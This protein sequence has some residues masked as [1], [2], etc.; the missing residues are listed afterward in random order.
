MLSTAFYILIVF[1]FVL[2][3]FF[4]LLITNLFIFL[5]FM[6]LHFLIRLF[7]L[8]NI[9]Q[10]LNF[11]ENPLIIISLFNFFCFVTFSSLL[12][13]GYFQVMS[14]RFISTIL[15]YFLVW[16][17]ILDTSIVVR[18]YLNLFFLN[19]HLRYYSF[20]KKKTL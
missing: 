3:S 6:L 1:L 12:V 17:Q 20:Q 4:L 14:T 15:F 2:T 13:Q 19:R 8:H 18:F 5:V 10:S 7:L 9:T 16:Y 11:I